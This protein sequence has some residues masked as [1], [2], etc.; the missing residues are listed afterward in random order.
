MRVERPEAFRIIESLRLGIPP[1]GAVR[2]LT[3]GRK[4][5]IE[6]L[7][8]RVQTG[9]A[10]LLYIK[11]NY[12]SGKTHLLRLIREY[13][14][15]HGYAVSV[16][17]LDATASVRF[18]RMDQIVGAV[19]RGLRVPGSVYTGVRGLFDLLCSEIQNSRARG[20][21]DGLWYRLTNRWKWNE[22]DVCESITM[23][24]ALRAWATGLPA[25]QQLVEDW[26]F[27]PWSYY[28]QRRRIYQELIGDLGR[29]FHDG[30]QERYYYPDAFKL[31][32]QAYDQS[33]K[34]LRDL[35]ML[36]AAAGLKGVII[37][38][39]EFENMLSGLKRSDYKSDA[40]WNLLQ[41]GRQKQ[42]PGLSVFAITP[43]FFQTLGRFIQE[44]SW[45]KLDY[46]EVGQFPTFEMQ[47]LEVPQL[48]ELA[49]RIRDTHALAFGWNPQQWIRDAALRGIVQ[50]S[51]AVPVQ[52]RSRQTIK[53]VVSALD[54]AFEEVQ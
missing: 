17:G 2:Y 26:L 41:F 49:G 12:G 39:D 46:S 3:V 43:E 38:F 30:H 35:R 54:A 52:D 47:P 29:Y 14:L 18:N 51:A 34:F 20:D 19:M 42:F 44:M 40:F 16:V 6:D 13:G 31:S 23:F 7:R 11:A 27:Q 22:S 21:A 9:G 8:R 50:K 10:G 15:E 28:T 48:Q 45:S 53:H 37:L 33:W 5:E 24:V 4:E 32:V 1:D 25:T 36:T